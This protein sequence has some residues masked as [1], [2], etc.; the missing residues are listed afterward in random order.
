MKRILSPAALILALLLLLIPLAG[1]SDP[2]TPDDTL[3][4]ADT[5]AAEDTDPPEET[6]PANQ[7]DTLGEHKYLGEKYIILSRTRTNY[8]YVGDDSTGDLIKTA[9]AKR[10]M[11]AEERLGVKIEV[12]AQPGDWGDRDTFVSAVQTAYA[13]GTRTYD[14]VSTHSAYIVNIGLSGYAYNMLDLPGVDFSKKWWCPQYTNNVNIDG[15]I[16]SAVGDIGY[17]LYEYTMCTFFNKTIQKAYNIP[18]LYAIVE[19]GEWTF[20]KML[21]FAYSVYE[22][23]NRN[24]T[25][26]KGD[27]FGVSMSGHNARMCQTVW[28]CG[29]T[30]PDD[31]G[32]QQININNERFIEAY[33]KLYDLVYNHKDH[34]I[35]ENEGANLTKEFT[36]DHI[37]FFTEK[38]LEAAYM[39]DM[40]S[41]YGIIPFPKYDSNQAEYISSSRDAMNAIA[42]MRNIDNPEMVGYMTEA[43]GMYGW[44]EITPAYYETT[45][46]YRYMSDPTAA[47]ML[48]LIRDTLRFD[49][50]MTFTNA[51]GLVYSVMGDN[52]QN[53]KENITSSLRSHEKL[54]QAYI[55]KIY[56][57]YANIKQ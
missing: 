43:L 23:A 57:T 56:E 45:L 12:V 24:N 5:T 35:F 29:I 55:D 9:V 11:N 7:R 4:S 53:A 6:V 52:L 30:V 50:A 32:R 22:D 21:E 2:V 51:I 33:A 16:Y 54:D 38:L 26:D 47:N 27:V 8:E 19:S 41:E 10:N 44:Q 31:T 39:K 48:D 3:P 14:L 37:L 25:P 40:D 34:C 15:Q 13:S 1:C 46:K 28:E 18:D 49:F 36:A 20:E 42:V 17:T